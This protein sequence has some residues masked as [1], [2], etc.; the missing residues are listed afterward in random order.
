[1][2]E[3]AKELPA[4]ERSGIEETLEF[5]EEPIDPNDEMKSL[6]LKLISDSIPIPLEKPL[7]IEELQ[8]VEKESEGEALQIRFSK[9]F[10][11]IPLLPGLMEKVILTDF[12]KEL[13]LLLSSEDEHWREWLSVDPEKEKEIEKTIR[14]FRFTS[15]EEKLFKGDKKLAELII[16]V[17][18]RFG[19][20]LPIKYRRYLVAIY[21][22]WISP[23]DLISLLRDR[24]VPSLPFSRNHTIPALPEGYAKEI[25]KSGFLEFY[26]KE[27]ERLT[28][29][30]DRVFFHPMSSEEILKTEEKT[31]YLL[32]PYFRDFLSVFGTKQEI[33][34]WMIWV[35]GAFGIDGNFVPESFKN[36]LYII[37]R[38]TKHGQFFISFSEPLD[39][40]VY[41][42]E[43]GKEKSLVPVGQFTDLVKNGVDAL[44]ETYD[45]L[46]PNS[47]KVRKAVLHFFSGDYD[48]VI[49]PILE[50]IDADE[51]PEFTFS[52]LEE[53]VVICHSEIQIKN[54]NII[55]ERH[56]GFDPDEYPKFLLRLTEPLTDLKTDS[57]IDFFVRCY[58]EEDIFGFLTEEDFREP[59]D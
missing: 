37:G 35:D 56:E 14:E 49:D 19:V 11:L 39:P 47:E 22:G 31:G 1:M 44:I 13:P 12:S 52:K 23:N 48:K 55:L 3:L 7:Q 29:H 27:A 28:V 25:G 10:E 4:K 38:G 6:A 8:W 9:L 36:T 42:L 41:L 46:R 30:S 43:F 51:L 26:L 40:T 24:R 32:P 57:F 17:S 54:R 16:A 33:L 18:G 58:E 53:D 21:Q 34:P 59:E 5:E 15:E 45:D 2:L 20:S 50:Y